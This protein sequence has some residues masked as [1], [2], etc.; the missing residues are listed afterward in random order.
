MGRGQGGST[1]YNKRTAGG[2]RTSS[3]MSKVGEIEAKH[4]VLGED[5]TSTDRIA[6]ANKE[7]LNARAAV[8]QEQIA[9]YD[10]D[11]RVQL[12]TFWNKY[13]KAVKSGAEIEPPDPGVVS[14]D[15]ERWLLQSKKLRARK[16]QAQRDGTQVNLPELKQLEQ[17]K[18]HE[19]LHDAMKNYRTAAEEK[20]E[21]KALAK[22]GSLKVYDNGSYQAHKVTTPEAL[23]K[24]AEGTHWCTKDLNTADQKLRQHDYRIVSRD[25]KPLFAIK[26]PKYAG[27]QFEIFH[28]SDFDIV[29]G[30]AYM[31]SKGQKKQPILEE[32]YKALKDVLKEEGAP[33]FDE[34]HIQI[35]NEKEKKAM[36][37]QAFASNDSTN[38]QFIFTSLGTDGVTDNQVK[39][40]MQKNISG[41]IGYM[42]A[43][44]KRLPDF[45]EEISK[46]P[47]LIMAYVNGLSS[48]FPGQHREA[49]EAQLKHSPIMS[50]LYASEY[51][52]RFPE[53][54][55]AIIK[56]D[57]DNILDYVK[58]IGKKNLPGFQEK[59][60]QVREGMTAKDHARLLAGLRKPL[61]AAQFAAQVEGKR[62]PELE[63]FII[64]DARALAVYA[65]VPGVESF[66]AKH[67]DYIGNKIIEASPKVAM[68]FAKARKQRLD[69]MKEYDILMDPE[70]SVPYI[71]MLKDLYGKGGVADQD[72]V[73][74][75]RQL[76]QSRNASGLWAFVK[77]FPKQRQQV[78][79]DLMKI[80]QAQVDDVSKYEPSKFRSKLRILAR[81]MKGKRDAAYEKLLL[82][83]EEMEIG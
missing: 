21:R 29:N 7:D 1:G 14:N 43:A 26:Y 44:K 55:E 49:A 19:E 20:A 42:R 74:M 82:E 31:V 6:A 75:G 38:A 22:S 27:G 34:K 11:R 53:G 50:M 56:G 83:I 23:S 72:L 69:L 67:E 8:F 54:E 18:T 60:R 61:K 16:Q 25:G 10:K 46:K 41:A 57:A 24:M 68:R 5:A 13:V 66:F 45:E 59:Y 15:I 30:N 80:I 33:D 48:R 40:M 35:I 39:T 51:G 64:R 79:D 9:G 62:M 77:Q 2:I 37:Q 32:D 28:N 65:N 73:T 76:A 12:E 17:Y 36:Y 58:A 71:S 47:V 52:G 3:K 4:G 81:L 78:R 70:A 63:K